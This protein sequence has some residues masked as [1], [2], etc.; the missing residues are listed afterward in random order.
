[1]DKHEILEEAKRRYNIGDL[2]KSA[3][4]LSTTE[5]L[6]GYEYKTFE[7]DALSLQVGNSY[8]YFYYKGKWAEIIES[9]KPIIKEV[10][11]YQIY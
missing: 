10:N 2:V 3:Y 11:S 6:T 8:M 5:R 1:M 4:D 9:S 7:D